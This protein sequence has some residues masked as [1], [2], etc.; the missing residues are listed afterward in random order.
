MTTEA[1]YNP[2]T[3]ARIR[4]GASAAD[5]GWSVEKYNRI[6][7]NHGLERKPRAVPSQNAL[8]RSSIG[9]VSY[10]AATGIVHRNYNDV[11]L[12]NKIEKL[13][14][15]YLFALAAAGNEASVSRET[16][17]EAGG[18]CSGPTMY[19]VIYRLSDRLKP[20]KCYVAT[21][22][23]KNGGYRLVVES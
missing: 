1:D 5:L 11:L 14:F 17:I 15:E 22:Y 8:G 7:A 10:D 6:C 23:G 16:L 3:L 13:V 12:A 9:Q 4:R 19:K 20:V 21:T 2:A 18:N